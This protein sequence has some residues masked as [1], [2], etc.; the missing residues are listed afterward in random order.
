MIAHR[1]GEWCLTGTGP[2][3][4]G[5]AI[6]LTDNATAAGISYGLSVTNNDNGA[7]AGVPAALAYL[8]NAN[9]AET[10]TDGLLVEQTGAGAL[11]NGIEIKRTAGTVT[12]GLTFTVTLGTNL[13]NAGSA[14]TVTAAGAGTFGSNLTV[15]GATLSLGNGSA[16]TISTPS[17]NANLTI[18]PNLTGTLNLATTNTG[19]VN[20][21]TATGAFPL[22][23]SG[24][25]NS[26]NVRAQTR[27]PP[28][29]SIPH[30]AVPLPLP[31]PSP[32]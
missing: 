26:R 3:E 14:L 24:G 30:V 12:N 2:N 21:G 1:S 9:A 7:N 13:I 20:I 8:K 17:G 16:A 31:P 28:I 22:P 25:L 18:A 11:T 29:D 4:T 32:L 27:A 10:V 23:S 15:N 6:A 19:A 5:L